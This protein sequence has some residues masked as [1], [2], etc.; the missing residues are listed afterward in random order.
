[1][2]NGLQWA[3]SG[4]R[5]TTE[6]AEDDGGLGQGGGAERKDELGMCFGEEQMP[7]LPN[8][9]LIPPHGR[10]PFPEWGILLRGYYLSHFREDQLLP[11]S[12]QAEWKR[13]GF[14]EEVS[15]EAA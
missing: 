13:V 4:Y 3:S 10:I 2:E 6:K 5:E 7:P 9:Y 1:M 8:P 14:L 11:T 15:R 12:F